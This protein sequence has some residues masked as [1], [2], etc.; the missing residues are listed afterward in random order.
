MGTVVNATYLMTTIAFTS[1]A[2]GVG[3]AVIPSV[4]RVGFGFPG[5]AKHSA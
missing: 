2:I 1:T 4:V 5:P 3:N